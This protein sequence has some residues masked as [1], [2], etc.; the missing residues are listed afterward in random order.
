[1]RL[2]APAAVATA[3]ALTTRTYDERTLSAA[4]A[5]VRTRNLVRTLAARHRAN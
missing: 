2:P 4:H 3:T 5:I 1:M